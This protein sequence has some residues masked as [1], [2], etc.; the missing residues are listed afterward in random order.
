[1]IIN[2]QNLEVISFQGPSNTTRLFYENVNGSWS[3]PVTIAGTGS[4]G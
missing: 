1:M 4:S 2:N 3:G